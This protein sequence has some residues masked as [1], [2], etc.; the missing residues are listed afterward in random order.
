MVLVKRSNDAYERTRRHTGIQNLNPLRPFYRR[1]LFHT[2]PSSLLSSFT[3]DPFSLAIAS[4]TWL[5]LWLC[6]GQRCRC[7]IQL[8]SNLSVCTTN[9][10]MGLIKLDAVLDM[11]ACHFNPQSTKRQFIANSTSITIVVFAWMVAFSIPPKDSN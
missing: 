7:R 2:C 6:G 5:S 10:L 8:A 9:R 11:T 4:R 3:P 1:A